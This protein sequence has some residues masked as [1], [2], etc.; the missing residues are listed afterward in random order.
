MSFV[1]PLNEVSQLLEHFNLPFNV[2]NFK[3]TR[4]A[5]HYEEECCVLLS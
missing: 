5:S 3:N 1:L 4:N 2:Q